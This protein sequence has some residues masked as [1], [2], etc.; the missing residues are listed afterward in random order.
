MNTHRALAP[1]RAPTGALTLEN[2]N[3]TEPL[4]FILEPHCSPAVVVGRHDFT[5]VIDGDAVPTTTTTKP[6]QCPCSL[7]F[8]DSKA[9]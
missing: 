7:A 2:G 5:H 3:R 8:M 9:A 4:E 6:W 1:D